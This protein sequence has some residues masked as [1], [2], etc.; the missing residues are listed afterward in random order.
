VAASNPGV[1]NVYATLNGTV[2]EPLAFVTCPPSSI[3]LSTSTDTSGI[4][5][6]PYSTADL[7]TLNKGSEQYVTATLT[8]TNG[9]PLVTLPLTDITSDPLTGSFSTFLP[10]TS[11]LTANTSG[12][13]TLMASCE[14]ATCNPAVA[15]FISP[16]GPSTGEA[17][18]FGY[19]IYSNVIGATVQGITG[20]TVLVTGTT[21]TDGVTPAH[22][23]LV[24][25]SESLALTQTVELANLP[26]SMM[27]APNGATAYLGSSAGLMVVNLTTY[28]T[29]L[30]TFPI[31]GGLSTDVVTG[32][33]LGIS[34]D[35]RYVLLSDNVSA[36]PD[37]Y[38]FLIDTTG[39]KTATRYTIPGTTSSPSVISAA[40]FAAD[41]SNTWIG[42][43]AGVYVFQSDTFV[44]T[45][46]NTSANVTS[47]AWTP[48]GQSYFASGGGNLINYST[49]NDQHPQTPAVIHTS[50]V[51][52]G[53]ST[54]ALSPEPPLP[55]DVPHLL[56]LDDTTWFDYSITSSSEVPIQ[57]VLALSALTPGGTGNVCKSTVAVNAPM[58]A[59][60][61]LLCTAQQ[62]SFSPTL[63]QEFITGVN[64][65]C[66][67]P[68]SVIH[69]YNVNTNS[70]ILLTTTNPVVPLSGGVLNDGRKLYFG[71]W[72]GAT[73]QTATLHRIDLSTG[74]GS[75][76]S[77][78][79]DDSVSISVVPSF[80]AVVPK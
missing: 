37:S 11:R 5:L 53:L 73:A 1:T 65:S 80:V 6:P 22:R 48:D 77:L 67:S 66:G 79:E 45:L 71:T 78:T 41:G 13:F 34:P 25:D 30:Q 21:F 74:T 62:L 47:L 26:N 59:A 24:Y 19:P 54:T 10:L 28:Q 50:S 55:G 4:P 3:V 70:E 64:P 39:T 7:T 56:G 49:C 36:A 20:S 61:T 51:T 31:V 32:T 33:V 9:L 42:G 43:T 40:T 57:S 69:G 46:T 29:T 14:P 52:Q 44:P 12:R 17:A 18:G 8:D 58:T 23:L 63:E 15:N 76:G 68:E 2:S 60:S 75:P 27:V 16:V 72:A 38:V 35:S